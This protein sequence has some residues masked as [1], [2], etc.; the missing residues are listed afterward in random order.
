M[1]V[2][3]VS[4]RRRISFSRRERA[5]ISKM[6][7]LFHLAD[8]VLNRPLLILPEKL[9]LIAQVLDGRIGIDSSG[10][11]SVEAEYLKKVSPGASR[12]VR[13]Y[14]P[15][16]PKNPA[17]GRKPYRTTAEGVAVIGVLGSLV[18]RGGW[19]RSIRRKSGRLQ[20]A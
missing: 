18:N 17:A 2:L 11:G 13:N 3:I 7:V 6:T 5:G 15:I 20:T 14:E 12:F 19:P 4:Y 16:D 8:R 9:T 1:N 10:L